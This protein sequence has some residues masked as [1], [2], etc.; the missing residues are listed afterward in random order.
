MEVVQVPSIGGSTRLLLELL[1]RFSLKSL[2]G[3][4]SQHVEGERGTPHVPT[5]G[6]GIIKPD[7]T[8]HSTNFCGTD[9]CS[10]DFVLFGGVY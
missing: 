6:C 4:A 7:A 9:Y 10:T 1:L 3:G 2:E 5:L 8:K